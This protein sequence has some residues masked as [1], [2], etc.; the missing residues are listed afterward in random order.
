MQ[1]SDRFEEV[2]GLLVTTAKAHHAATGGV[3]PRWARWYAEHLIDD[4]NASLDVHFDVDQ[5]EAWLIDADVRYRQGPQTASWP[6]AYA[7]WLVA[8]HG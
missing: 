6:K 1:E 5:L 7:S 4:L 2:A 8:E 3:N